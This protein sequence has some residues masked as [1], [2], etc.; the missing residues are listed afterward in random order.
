MRN[1][2]LFSIQVLSTLLMLVSVKHVDIHIFLVYIAILV[3]T[4]CAKRTQQEYY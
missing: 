1:K 2:I 3:L 4:A